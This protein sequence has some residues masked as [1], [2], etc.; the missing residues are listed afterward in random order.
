MN[1]LEESEDDM[2]DVVHCK[3]MEPPDNTDILD[4]K[5]GAICRAVYSRKFYRVKVVESGELMNIMCFGFTR[6]L[7]ISGNIK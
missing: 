6:Q 7:A 4:V 3:N 1:W 5:S 2:Y